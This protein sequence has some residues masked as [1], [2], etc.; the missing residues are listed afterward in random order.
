[1]LGCEDHPKAEAEYLA[2]VEYSSRVSGE[3]GA[4]FVTEEEA[5]LARARQFPEAWAPLPTHLRRAMPRRF[6]HQLQH[7]SQSC[8]QKHGR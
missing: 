7:E 5:A 6:P 3:W 2:A 8:R 4:R 1:V